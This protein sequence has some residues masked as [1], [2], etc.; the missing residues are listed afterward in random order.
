MEL[1]TKCHLAE[2]VYADMHGTNKME[3]PEVLDAFFQTMNS[4]NNNA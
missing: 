4:L 3:L 2:T 1:I